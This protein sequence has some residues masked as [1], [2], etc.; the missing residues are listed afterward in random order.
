MESFIELIDL[1]DH[2]NPEVRIGA[3]SA[4][5]QYIEHKEYLSYVI[6]NPEKTIKSLIS[7]FKDKNGV[8]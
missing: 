5:L 1:L 8:L 4:F 7:L 6:E 3:L 2:Q